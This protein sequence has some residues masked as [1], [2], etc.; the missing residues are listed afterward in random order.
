MNASTFAEL[1][2]STK[3]TKSLESKGFTEPTP[4]QAA[5]IPLLLQNQRDIF[6]QAQT[7]TGKTAA[8][9]LPLIEKIV[10]NGK[11]Q[12]LILTPT[13]E[14]A[15]Q[16]CKEITSLR[17]EKPLIVTPVYGGQG[18]REQ[19]KALKSKVDVIVGTPGRIIDH[20]ERKSLQLASVRYLVLDEADE[21]LNMG[22]ADDVEKILIQTPKDR[23]LLLFSATLPKSLEHMV[24][25]YAKDPQYVRMKAEMKTGALTEQWFIDINNESERV[26]LLTK[27]IDIA[28][29]F[30]GVIFCRT[31]LEV[32]TV[33]AELQRAGYASA[34]IHGDFKQSER[35]RILQ[36][37]RKRSIKLLVATDVAARGLDVKELSHVI[38]FS[39]PGT[40]ETYVHRIGRT[41]R[42]GQKGTAI[43]LVSRRDFRQLQFIRKITRFDIQKMPEPSVKAI[44][45]AQV[46]RIQKQVLAQVQHCHEGHMSMARHL[47]KQAEP[48]EI[49]ASLLKQQFGE[50]AVA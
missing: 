48:L 12:A 13:R 49:I 26:S 43:S 25:R 16:V 45:Q 40:P 19:L 37:F 6:G 24:Q 4:I 17:G 46:S 3:L 20:L 9:A 41:G 18:M 50:K 35:E 32:D 28:D 38:N 21:M 2:L 39:L 29:D 33:N 5:V 7:G 36:L 47:L 14:L 1:G 31:K 27:L 30:Y 8:F 10:P 23:R 22:F 15:L 11:A 34:G 44:R 42:A